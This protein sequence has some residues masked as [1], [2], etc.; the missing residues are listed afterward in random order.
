[1]EVRKFLTT[2][3]STTVYLMELLEILSLWRGIEE[4]SSFQVLVWLLISIICSYR[5]DHFVFRI[6]SIFKICGFMDN[7]YVSMWL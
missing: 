5:I 3:R 6:N 7:T 1:M 2:V 4:T